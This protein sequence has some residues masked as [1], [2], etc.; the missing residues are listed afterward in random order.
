MVQFLLKTGEDSGMWPCVSGLLSSLLLL[1]IS[2]QWGFLA[3]FLSCFSAGIWP[4]FHHQ[5]SHLKLDPAVFGPLNLYNLLH[6]MIR[7]FESRS[8]HTDWIDLAIDILLF[9]NFILFSPPSPPS[10]PLAFP[11]I[12]AGPNNK[13]EHYQKT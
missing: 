8:E 4:H 1:I 2:F 11:G 10:H 7:R 6:R 9:L 3:L 13:S 5:T 12:K